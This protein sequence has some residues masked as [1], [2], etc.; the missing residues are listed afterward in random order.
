MEESNHSGRIDSKESATGGE[1]FGS[2]LA[3]SLPRCRRFAR[4][5]TRHVADADDLVQVALERALAHRGQWREDAPLEGWMFGIIKN[6]WIDE[7][8]RRQRAAAVFAPE[9]AGMDVGDHSAE[10]TVVAVSMQQAM[11]KLPDEQRLAVALVLVEGLSYQ[12][13]AAVMEVPVGT[14]TSRLARAREALMKMLEP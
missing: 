8:R 11:E 1:E 6:A 12:E 3:T 13:A 9:E 7:L 2:R 10:V 14:L 5:L 4:A